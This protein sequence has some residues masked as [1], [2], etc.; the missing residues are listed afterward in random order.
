MRVLI[1]GGGG[2][3]GSALT[4]RILAETDWSV[5]AV[6]LSSHRLEDLRGQA[7]LEFLAADITR[8]QPLIDRLIGEADVVLPLAAT[9]LPANYV[10][11]PLGTFE[12]DFEENLRIVR[13]IARAGARLIFPS[14]SEV[15][16][17]CEDPEFDEAASPLVLG[18][19]EKER[20]IYS[21]SKQLLDRVIWALG[22]QGLKF[23]LFRPFNWFGPGLDDI[24][25]SAPGSARVVTQFL[26]HL[27]RGEPLQLVD[28]GAQRRTFTHVD[29]GIEGLM[30]I[31]ANPGGQADGGIFNLGNP[32]NCVSIR[33]L[34]LTMIEELS[35]FS[36]YEALAG[37]AVLQPTSGASYYGA[38]YEDTVHRR[39]SIAA[40]ARLGWSPQVGLRQGLRDLIAAELATGRW[41][42][43]EALPARSVAY[44]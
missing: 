42:P 18:P 3:I 16:G 37:Q 40:A 32:D 41:S 30:R 26:G 11:D 10:R 15:Y 31:L 8:D 4:R 17:M 7:R 23:T 9:A 25:Q 33:E 38:G 28:G 34:A 12:L 2:F 43:D 44:G 5:R 21:C 39:P 13:Q 14:T 27:L 20:W 22:G 36:G 35:G 1:L 29:D 24:R 6:D 19:I